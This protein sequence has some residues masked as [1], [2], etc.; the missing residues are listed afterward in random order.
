VKCG[1]NSAA[2]LVSIH[3]RTDRGGVQTTGNSIVATLPDGSILVVATNLTDDSLP[4][5]WRLDGV[6]GLSAK[7]TRLRIWD[8]RAGNEDLTLVGE[9]RPPA[10]TVRP[11]GCDIAYTL[12]PHSVSA[13][14]I[15]R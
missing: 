6:K 11:T 5:T 8:A 9:E 10:L 3:P 12:P 1:L 2:Q 13:L 14:K 15:V 7:R 4:A